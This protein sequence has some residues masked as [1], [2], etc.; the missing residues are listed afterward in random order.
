MSSTSVLARFTIS[1]PVY[2]EI[3]DTPVHMIEIRSAIAFLYPFVPMHVQVAVDDEV[4]FVQG[5]FEA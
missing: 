1:I 4:V 2:D 3:G 5:K